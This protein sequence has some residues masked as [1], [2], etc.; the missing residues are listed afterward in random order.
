MWLPLELT[1]E[2]LGRSAAFLAVMAG[3]A[4]AAALGMVLAARRPLRSLWPG[5]VLA[6]LLGALLGASVAV[7]F[8]LPDPGTFRV[9]CREIPLVWSVGGALAGAALA[10]AWG[11]F[12]RPRPTEGPPESPA[13]SPGES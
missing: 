8:G 13:E 6:A 7:R 3:F 10:W 1:L 5:P 4:V 11:R 2:Y 12:R 9:W